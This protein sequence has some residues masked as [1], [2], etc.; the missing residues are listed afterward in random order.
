MVWWGVWLNKTQYLQTTN[1]FRPEVIFID[2]LYIHI[3][4]NI[5]RKHSSWWRR[6]LRFQDV[7][8]KTKIFALFIL[9]QKTSSRRYSQDQYIHLGHTSSRR[10]QYVSQKRLQNVLLRRLQDIFKRLQDIFKTSSRHLL[11]AFKTFCENVFKTSSRHLQDV[12]QRCLQNVFKTY[13][14]VKLF[15]LTHFIPLI[16]F[17]TRWKH[18]K[19]SG[20]LRFQGVSRKIGGMKWVRKS[21]RRIQH[22]SKAYCKDGYQQK[23]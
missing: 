16:F 9:L 15:L 12:L 11:N 19:T 7:L 18:Q 8:I 3:N 23:D 1:Y 22:V 21:S 6:R 14:Q 2:N 10:L 4:M 5:Y 20:F 17:D 13:H